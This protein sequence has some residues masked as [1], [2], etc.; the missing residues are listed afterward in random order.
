MKRSKR[1]VGVALLGVALVASSVLVAAPAQ[2]AVWDCSTGFSSVGP[3]GT[4]F[5]SDITNPSYQIRI[6]CRNIFTG[7]TYVKGGNWVGLGQTSTI[8]GCGVFEQYYGSPW[9]S[10]N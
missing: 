8:Q 1:I 3:Y 6:L 7:S 4:C 10:S 9:V 2:A 5:S